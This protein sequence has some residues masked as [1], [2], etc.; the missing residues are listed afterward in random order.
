M[1]IIL[2]V[3]PTNGEIDLLFQD[4]IIYHF[5]LTFSTAA[6]SSGSSYYFKFALDGQFC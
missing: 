6:I 3:D 2:T 5:G 1:K 4:I